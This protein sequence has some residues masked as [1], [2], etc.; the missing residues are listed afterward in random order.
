M[1]LEKEM[2]EIFYSTGFWRSPSRRDQTSISQW[3]NSS[4]S[5]FLSIWTFT[6][7]FPGKTEG[8]GKE[9]F[10]GSVVW[11]FGNGGGGGGRGFSFLDCFWNFNLFIVSIQ[12]LHLFILLLNSWCLGSGKIL[13]FLSI[14]LQIKNTKQIKV[15]KIRFGFLSFQ[16][17]LFF[18][19]LKILLG[20]YFKPILNTLAKCLNQL[21]LW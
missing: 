15:K 19:C 1:E 5:S 3:K 7:N 10:V 14:H 8:K 11:W 2:W 18:N 21:R 17:F 20:Y 4:S 6:A 12:V 16:K 13:Y 9:N